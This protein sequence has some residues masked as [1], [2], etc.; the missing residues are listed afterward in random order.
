VDRGAERSREQSRAEQW[1][2][3]SRETAERESFFPGQQSRRV[4]TATEQ[5]SRAEESRRAYRTTELR[6]EQYM[7]IIANSSEPF[8]SVLSYHILSYPVR[9]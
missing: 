5:R 6:A 8:S 2:E 1:S 9:S 4:G 7:C 3:R